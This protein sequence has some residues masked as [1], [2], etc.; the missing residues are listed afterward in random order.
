MVLRR[1]A[2]ETALPAQVLVL[3]TWGLGWRFFGSA[4]TYM[5]GCLLAMIFNPRMIALEA[6][7]EVETMCDVGGRTRTIERTCTRN[8]PSRVLMGTELYAACAKA[9]TRRRLGAR[10]SIDACRASSS[11]RI[12]AL[13]RLQG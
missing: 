6:F 4:A 7:L 8:N 3:L 2:F 11:I 1:V 10:G 13:A 9:S 5:V 12:S